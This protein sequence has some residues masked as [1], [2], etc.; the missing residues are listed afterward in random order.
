MAGQGELDQLNGLIAAF[1]DGA[2]R[3]NQPSRKSM[4][5]I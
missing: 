5:A 4:T 3:I 1:E 2:K